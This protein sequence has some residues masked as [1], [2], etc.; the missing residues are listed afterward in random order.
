MT[1][2]EKKKL[3]HLLN[4]LFKHLLDINSFLKKL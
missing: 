3:N 4:Y 1:Y 2:V